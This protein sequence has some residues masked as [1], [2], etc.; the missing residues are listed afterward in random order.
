LSKEQRGRLDELPRERDLEDDTWILD[1]MSEE[2][3]EIL[4]ELPRETVTVR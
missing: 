1:D 3:R 4:D 2:Q